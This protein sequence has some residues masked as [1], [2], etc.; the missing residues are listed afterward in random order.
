[1]SGK[2]SV[3]KRIGH[4]F[5]RLTD[6]VYHGIAKSP[7]GRFFTAYPVSDRAFRESGTVHMTHLVHDPK[8]GSP[9]R[10]GAAQAMDQSFLRRSCYRLIN[11]FCHCSLRSLGAFFVTMGVYAALISWLIAT[12]WQGNASDA[13]QLYAGFAI[14]VVG[15]LLLFSERSVGYALIK[16]MI[17]GLVMRELLG[18]SEDTLK[19]IPKTGRG[20]YATLVP[21]GMLVGALMAVIGP[22]R[23]LLILVLLALALMAFTTPEAGTVLLP[24]YAP[25]M[26]FVPYGELWLCVGV[27]IPLAGYICKLLRGTRSFHMEIQDFIVMAMIVFS[28]LSALSAGGSQA[29]AGAVSAALLMAV[30]F[31]AINVL[32]TPHWLVRCRIALLCS[33]TATALVGIMQFII[34]AVIAVEGVGTVTMAELGMATKAGFADHTTFAY[35]MVLAFPFA[36]HA[37]VRARPKHRMVAGFTC[38]TIAVASVLA[39]VQS[40]WLALAV[41]VLVICLL[42]AKYT[43]PYLTMAGMIT[44]GVIALLPRSWRQGM[45]D[46]LIHSADLSATRTGVAGDIATRL[47]FEN[48]NGFFGIGPGISR[49]LFGLGHNGLEAVCALY[50]TLPVDEA[51]GTFNFFLYRLVQEGLPGLL[52]PIALLLL[53]LQNCFSVLHAALRDARG[54]IQPVAGVVLVFG[55]V[56][57]GIFRYSWY[58]PA[59][60]L[61]FFLIIALVTADARHR[62]VRQTV[63]AQVANSDFFV[64]MEYVLEKKGVAVDPEAAEEDTARVQDA[65]EKDAEAPV[66]QAQT[67]EAPDESTASKEAPV[68]DTV[69]AQALDPLATAQAEEPQCEKEVNQ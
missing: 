47:F 8:R 1:M 43:F 62:R 64:E 57:I 39:F 3:F 49:L 59:A 52:L 7:I 63:V 50:T 5:A 24:L 65:V 9:L 38:V 20:E 13:F 29:V 44:P 32:A 56:T 41:E 22:M 35:F 69:G 15:V 34:S 51:A 54:P 40:A 36:L 53:L 58:D 19:D 66:M 14:V 17:P 68:Q 23:F 18:F 26:G 2:P 11:A 16:G 28:L 12:V 67:K 27:F 33:A 4:F 42:C 46:T 30:Y 6:T 55:V 25:F 37:F 48:G 21:L 45:A 61:L 31:P 60:L 10:R